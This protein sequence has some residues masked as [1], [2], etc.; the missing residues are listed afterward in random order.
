MRDQKSAPKIVVDKQIRMLCIHYSDG[1]GGLRE[2]CSIAGKEFPDG[3][4]LGPESYV[5]AFTLKR[6]VYGADPIAQ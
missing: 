3:Y 5:G 1:P 2:L 4:H 6:L